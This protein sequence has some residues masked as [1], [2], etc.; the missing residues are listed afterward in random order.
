MKGFRGNHALKLANQNARLDPT[1][2]RHFETFRKA[3]EALKKHPNN[4]DALYYR[5]KARGYLGDIK[6][7][8]ID[9]DRV[10]KI[11]DLAWR[12][13]ML[14]ATCKTILG[15]H[16]G[17][18]KD[19]MMYLLAFNRCNRQYPGETEVVRKIQEQLKEIKGELPFKE[20]GDLL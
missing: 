10:I 18:K 14:R 1:L 12:A 3:T 20:D 11:N 9:L 4:I 6:G 2:A 15:D 13:Y 17:A 5:A 7:S 8:L 19:K 16:E